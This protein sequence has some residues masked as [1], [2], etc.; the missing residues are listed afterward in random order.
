MDNKQKGPRVARRFHA[1]IPKPTSLAARAAADDAKNAR[2]RARRHRGRRNVTTRGPANFEVRQSSDA[3]AAWRRW[4]HGS[5]DS[6]ADST[7]MTGYCKYK[8]DGP[9]NSSTPGR[10]EEATSRGDP[11]SC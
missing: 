4:Q 9:S 6:A 3:P 8:D 2:G 5:D 10:E 11:A 1:R 7:S